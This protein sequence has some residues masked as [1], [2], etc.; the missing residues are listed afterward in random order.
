[1]QPDS[2]VEPFFDAVVSQTRLKAVFSMQL[3][4]PIDTNNSTDVSMGG[5]MVSGLY[6][7]RHGRNHGERFV[8]RSAWEEPW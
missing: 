1:M 7:G 5:T 2:S 3:C 4:G 8:F 6:S